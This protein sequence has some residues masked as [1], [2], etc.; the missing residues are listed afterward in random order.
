MD[1]IQD[2]INQWDI[3]DYNIDMDD[4]NSYTFINEVGLIEEEELVLC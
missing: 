1:T 4:T 3:I 2:I